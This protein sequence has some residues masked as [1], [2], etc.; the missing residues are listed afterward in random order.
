MHFKSSFFS[1]LRLFDAQKMTTLIYRRW[2]YY[3]APSTIV[4]ESNLLI[5]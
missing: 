2:L 5:F 4:S 3:Q 1:K